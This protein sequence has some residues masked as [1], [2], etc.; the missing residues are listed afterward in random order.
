MADHVLEYKPRNYGA[1]PKVI[2]YKIDKKTTKIESKDALTFQNFD[3]V[4]VYK[5]KDQ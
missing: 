2:Y 1:I 5:L 4:S 3:D